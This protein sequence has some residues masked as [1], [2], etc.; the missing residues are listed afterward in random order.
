MKKR[1]LQ[2]MNTITRIHIFDVEHGECNAIETPSGDLILIGAGHNSSTNWRPSNWLRQRNQKPHCVILSNLDS[3]HL[4]DLSN[5][6]PDIRPICIKYNSYVNPDW[7]EDTK[8]EES[9]EIHKGVQ[10]ALYWIR[11]VFTG[12]PKY[13]NYGMEIAYFYHS[14]TQFN[15]TNNLSVVTFIAYGGIGVLFPGDLEVLGWKEHLKNP[16]FV[17]CLRRTKILIA[18]HHGRKSGYCA[19]VFNY[20]SPDVVVISDKSIEYDTQA[21]NLYQQHT[22][23]LR[24]SN[25]ELRK[26]LTTRSDGKMT[27][28]INPDGTY[29]LTLL[30]NSYY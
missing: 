15:D 1:L 2:N 17:N 11:N 4:S 12:G 7:V 23:G 9:G 14:P 24:F 6:E 22:T 28:E 18:S 3:D 16:K 8:V 25:G 10:T 29:T 20:C 26:V 21:H 30:R 13:H 5:F 27:I 19:E